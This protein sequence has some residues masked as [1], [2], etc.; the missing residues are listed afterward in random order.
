V[1]IERDDFETYWIGAL[2]AQV[3]DCR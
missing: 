1:A 3:A 2:I